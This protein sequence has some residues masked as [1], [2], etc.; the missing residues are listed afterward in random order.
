MF[1]DIDPFDQPTDPS[2]VMLRFQTHYLQIESIGL[3]PS[4]RL[5]N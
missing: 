4:K 3:I 2:A 5:V 1:Q